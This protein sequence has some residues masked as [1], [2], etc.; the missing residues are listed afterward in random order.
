MTD[1]PVADPATGRVRQCADLCATCIY[2]PGN[3]AH[4]RRGRVKQMTEEALATE[5]HI[6]CHSTLY[7]AAP[8]ICAGFARHPLAATRSLALRVVRSGAATLHLITP[9]SKETS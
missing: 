9:P 6:V 7:T 2:H 1:H 8:A 5:G 3:R 4:L